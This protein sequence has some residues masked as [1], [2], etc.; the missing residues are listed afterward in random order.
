MYTTHYPLTEDERTSFDMV[1]GNNQVDW[2]DLSTRRQDAI[3]D[4]IRKYPDVVKTAVWTGSDL[5]ASS[6]VPLSQ[7]SHLP[8]I[9]SEVSTKKAWEAYNKTKGSYEDFCDFFFFSLCVYL[10]LTFI[11]KSRQ[12]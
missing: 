4:L 5:V 9:L 1:I 6:G 8:D 2:E 10:Q 11:A 7:M 12:Q 3:N